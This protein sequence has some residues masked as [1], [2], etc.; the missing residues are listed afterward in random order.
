MGGKRH[1]KFMQHACRWRKRKTRVS[2]APY[3]G[4]HLLSH[5]RAPA[6]ECS[7][8]PPARPATALL[9]QPPQPLPPP[10]AP[11]AEQ[12]PRASASARPG[13]AGRAGSASSLGDGAAPRGSGPVAAQRGTGVGPARAPWVPSWVSSPPSGLK[14]VREPKGRAGLT[15]AKLGL[16]FVRGRGMHRLGEWG[17]WVRRALPRAA[18]LPLE[19]ARCGSDG[20]I[21]MGCGVLLRRFQREP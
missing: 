18:S 7:R 13:S 5:C 16:C 8:R 4:M 14:R 20:R 15:V 1:E 12:E 19:E 9:P 10:L 11:G 6:R 2:R 17:P 3:R 21:L